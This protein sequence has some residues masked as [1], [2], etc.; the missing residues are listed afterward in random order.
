MVQVYSTHL[1][2]SK[3]DMHEEIAAYK[4][5]N[6]LS[7]EVLSKTFSQLLSTI[8]YNF[9]SML[10]EKIEMEEERKKL[11]EKT[12]LL[13]QELDKMKLVYLEERKVWELDSKEEL[14]LL[15]EEKELLAKTLEEERALSVKVKK[16][17]SSLTTIA[18][19]T[20]SVMAENKE[21]RASSV[22]MDKEH[23]EKMNHFS[24]LHEERLAEVREENSKKVISLEEKISV[25]ESSLRLE[26]KKL[27]E[28]SHILERCENDL[29]VSDG[30]VQKNLDGFSIK[31]KDYT[32]KIEK[33]S[34]ELV[35]V[36][37]LYNQLLGK[38][39]VLE[40]LEKKK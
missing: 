25:V 33:L 8:D 16:E 1:I 3:E 9:S 20:S 32:L 30:M 13:D 38:V 40:S 14:R 36:N 21:L 7:K 4:H 17:L 35:G 19:Q 29:K 10:Q 12:T 26:E 5:I 2:D 6:T 15:R 31:E 27:F 24:K 11:A 34:S 39:D 22:L 28:V 18:E 23:R 37:S